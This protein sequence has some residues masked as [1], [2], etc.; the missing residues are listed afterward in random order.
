M[1]AEHEIRALS[2]AKWRWATDGP[3]DRL[4][5]LFDDELVFVHLNGHI[6]SKPEWMGELRS[7]RF[8]YDRIET[9]ETSVRVYGD[10]AIVVARGTFT[11]NGGMVF[12]L[13]CTEVYA[14]RADGW[15]LV[16]LHACQ[17]GY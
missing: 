13:V 12:K 11:I 17:D 9:H 4:E 1:P 15:K 8:V 2:D 6:T 3:L 16:S 7:Q 10:A 14:Q 5:D